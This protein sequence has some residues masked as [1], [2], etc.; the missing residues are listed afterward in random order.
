[1]KDEKKTKQQLL[2]ELNELRQQL[3]EFR[4]SKEALVESEEK[5]RS[6]VENSPALI[7]IVD[8]EYRFIYAN[9]QLQSF[10][11]YS[12]EEFI[13]LDF[14]KVLTPES[15]VMVTDRYI[16]RQR[17]EEVPSRYEITVERKDGTKLSVEMIV[18]IIRDASGRPRSLGQMLDNG[19]RKKAEE[20]LRFTQFA[21]DHSPD[22]AFWIGPEGNFVYVNEAACRSLGYTRDELLTMKVED[23][24]PGLSKHVWPYHWEELRL[25]RSTAFESRHK[26]KDGRIFPVEIRGNFVEFEGREYCCTFARDIT[27]RKQAEEALKESEERLRTIGD[28]IPAGMIYQIE[29]E[30]DGHYHFTYVSEAVRRLHG[31]APEA[32]LANA[33]L[34]YGHILPEYL[35]QL[36][37]LQEESFRSLSVFNSEVPTRSPSGGVRWVQVVS[38]PRRLGGDR[39]VWDGIEIDITERKQFE[40]SLR[41]RLDFEALIMKIS[42]GF[43][44][45]RPEELDRGI[46]EALAEVG[47]YIG[48]DR[49][50]IFQFSDDATL[51]DNTHE[52]C[53]EGVKPHVHLLKGLPLVDFP[54]VQAM[55]AEGREMKISRVADLPPE[56]AEEK[57]GF[58]LEGIQSVL[59]VPMMSAGRV[60]GFL[61]LDSVG[62]ERDWPDELTALVRIVGEILAYALEHARIELVLEE[63]RRFLE[64]NQR[65]LADMIEHSGA[66]ILVKD[67]LGRYEFI[68][69][70]W[71][72]VTG[73]SR[74]SAI[75]YTDEELFPGPVG[76]QFREND[77]A[78]MES[79]MVQELEEYLDDPGGRRFFISIKFPLY[80]ADGSITGICGMVTEIT[81]RK[82]AEE[83]LSRSETRFRQMADNIREVFWLLDWNEQRF[84]YVSPAYKELWGRSMEGLYDRFDEWR[85]SIYPEDLPF[86]ERSLAEV[87]ET[88]KGR[89]REYRILRPDGEIRWVSDRAFAVREAHG[90]VRYVTGIAEDITERRMMEEE[91]ARSH[92]LDSVA[93]LAGGI[94]H[95]F[96]NLLMAIMGN[97]NLSK[98]LIGRESKAYEVMERAERASLRAVDLTKQL[99]TFA[100]GGEPVTKAVSIVELVQE[101]VGLALR[102]SNVASKLFVHQQIWPVEVDEGQM[103]QVIYNLIINASQAMPGGGVI[104]VG[105]ENIL[106][107]ERSGLPVQKGRYVKMLIQDR[108]VGISEKDLTRIYDPFF[109]TK[110]K[111]RGLGLTIV[112]SIVR[113]HHGH[114]DVESS[115]GVGTTFTVYLPASEGVI[116]PL[117]S[118]EPIARGIGRVLIMDDEEAVREV[119]G[120]MLTYL[121]YEVEFAEDGAGAVELY[122]TRK[123]S[124][125]PFDA[126]I[127]DLTI[128]GG[129]GGIEAVKQLRE[130]DR[131]AKVVVSSGYSQD[132][133]MADYRE[134]GFDAVISKPYI[135]ATLGEVMGGL[136]TGSHGEK[137]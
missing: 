40:E 120:D 54:S 100:Q 85:E 52:W 71:E 91:L 129:I 77:L 31:C 103:N 60:M 75:G 46:D 29:R 16:R 57:A 23:I 121:G 115:P 62:A 10:L 9:Q 67:R 105:I 134:Y 49:S 93:V 107:G 132:P 1:M 73:L 34:I 59:M 18:A 8:D 137:S 38:R 19:E 76:R 69:S 111:G 32:V 99:L 17:S 133:V 118:D 22:E 37:R 14:R 72:E 84:V 56:Y 117:A 66:L 12:T 27:E 25:K 126:V 24:D 106:I 74:E 109:T 70:K 65:F 53:A 81:E 102:G 89:P 83:A 101:A 135:L 113:R 127:M 82:R 78:V 26:T 123:D 43:I 3:S 90:E 136:L 130:I 5:F 20:A 7:F 80:G 122:R 97:I 68:N 28:N 128:P 55:L 92:K 63:N 87:V 79:G 39:T 119:A 13:G 35:P 33:G 15:L 6:L 114:V 47:Q 41:R 112:Y 131:D 21:V 30:P 125:R 36:L 110:E 58:K 64:E 51:M 50:Y 4:R 116:D 48:A 88:G 11:G 124:L 61:G 108:G 42:T 95:D 104:R 2:A 94:A 86:A 96:N 45:R 44:N 98:V